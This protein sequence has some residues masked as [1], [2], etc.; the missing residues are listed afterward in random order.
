MSRPIKKRNVKSYTRDIESLGR[1]RTAIMMDQSLDWAHANKSIQQIDK[2][3]ASLIELSNSVVQ[4]S[5]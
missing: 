5:A 4:K 1:L 3:I 2:L